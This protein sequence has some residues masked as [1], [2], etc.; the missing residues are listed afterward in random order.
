M[1]PEADAIR[2]VQ[3]RGEADIYQLI[4]VLQSANRDTHHT[5][6]WIKK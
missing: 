6:L 1:S 4:R 2:Y 5:F 3:D